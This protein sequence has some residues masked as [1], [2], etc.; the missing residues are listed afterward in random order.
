MP[1]RRANLRLR[2]E[3]IGLKR[4]QKI[5]RRDA[6]PTVPSEDQQLDENHPLAPARLLACSP[7]RHT[8]ASAAAKLILC[9]EHAVVYGRPAIALPLVG[10]C[11]H[12]DVADAPAGDGIV[13]HARDLRRRWR[14]AN[15][16]NG[17]IS[18]LITSVLSYLQAAPAPD[19]RITISSTIPIASGMGSGAAVATAIVRALVA[20]LGR[21]IAPAEISALVYASEQ[22]FHGTPSGIDNTVIAYEQPIWFVRAEDGRRKPEDEGSDSSSGFRPPSPIIESIAI[23]SP[24]MLLIGET[25]VRSATRLPVGAVR[26]RW[27]A[28]PARYEALFDQVGTIVAQVRAALED[29]I[30]ALGPLLSQNHW[31]LQ[32]IGVSAPELDRL[33]E[34]A[35]AAGALGAKLSG[36]GWGGVMLAL[37]THDTRARVAAALE[38]AGAKR[39]SATDVSRSRPEPAAS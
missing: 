24:F 26:R 3:I 39:V 1:R 22:R 23:A 20:H 25:G 30:S 29:D 9:G 21:Q 37:V 17:P 27:Q 11:A 36:A 7:A 33:V 8:S 6:R 14:V 35:L 31:L 16:P 28:A 10:I 18:Q 32:Q 15:D 12:A 5:A 4:D 38:Q 2:S 13:V 34:A 19:L